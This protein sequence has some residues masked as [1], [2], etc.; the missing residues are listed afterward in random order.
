MR[1]ASVIS[2]AKT[3]LFLMIMLL[4]GMASIAQENSP[5]SRYGWGNL[6]GASPVATRSMGGIG[7]GYVD[8]DSRY[9]LKYQYPRSQTINFLNPASYA[10]LKITSFDLGFDL[11]NQV[12]S[13]KGKTD[14]FKASF[15]NISY[16]QLGVPLSRKRNLAMVIGLKPVSRVNYQ[17]DDRKRELNPL[18]GSSIDSTLTSYK[19][20]GGSYQAYVG[21]GKSFKNLSVGVNM[22]YY[23]GTK[24]F[25]T[26]KQFINDSVFYYKA[27]YQTKVNFGGIFFQTGLQ[28]AAN[29]NKSLRLVIGA[30]ATFKRDYAAR[31]DNVKETFEYDGNGGIIPRD[32]AFHQSDIRSTVTF[33]ASY[34]GGFTLEKRDKWMVGVDYTV[35]NWDDFR[36][37]GAKDSVASNWKIRVGGQITPN[38]FGTNY[39]GRVSYRAGFNYGPDYLRFNN[40]EL[41]QYTVTFG[42]G[43]PIRPNRFSNQ[44]STINA[45]FEFGRR[46]DANTQ[47]KENLFRLSL[48]FTLS[49]L[50]FVKRK[51]D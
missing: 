10:K 17:I 20:T 1:L 44:Y 46:G 23:F 31:L 2:L 3:Q 48:G 47:L 36:V 4:C 16:V 14:K 30:T 45:G 8:Y 29:L 33:P 28:Y 32:S 19:G 24:D 21:L 11:E 9:D 6:V 42:M 26:R 15:A 18:T 12:L 43:L 38:A 34:G 7:I 41:M 39:W 25:S 50:W 13:E 35:T 22:G 49:D 5:Y 40:Q 37:N 27:N 51:Y